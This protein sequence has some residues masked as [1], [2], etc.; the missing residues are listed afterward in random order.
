MITDHKHNENKKFTSLSEMNHTVDLQ[1]K[2]LA[3][4]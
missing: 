2:F 1:I 3:T 4:V